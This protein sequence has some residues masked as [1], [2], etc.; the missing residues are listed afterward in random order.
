MDEYFKEL[1]KHY[2]GVAAA[3]LIAMAISVLIREPKVNIL[4]IVLGVLV[5]FMFLA[6]SILIFKYGR[7]IKDKEEKKNGKHDR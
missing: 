3:V 2:L 1:S 6:I 7:R 4:S 5:Y